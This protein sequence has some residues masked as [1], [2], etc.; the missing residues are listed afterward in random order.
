M[1]GFWTVFIVFFTPHVFHDPVSPCMIK[2]KIQDFYLSYTII[3]N[4][5]SSEM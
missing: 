3:Q 1:S 5:T 4:I 2:F